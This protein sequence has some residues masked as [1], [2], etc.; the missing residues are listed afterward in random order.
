M[1][2]FAIL[3]KKKHKLIISRD[4]YGVKPFYYY[5]NK[6]KIIFSSEIKGI[7]VSNSKISFDENKIV[8]DEKYLE[9]KFTTLFK[10][11]EILPP[12]N[13]FEIDINPKQELYPDVE[14]DRSAP[15]GGPDLI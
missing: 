10:N 3:D 15:L 7:Y 6:N 8:Y 5:L 14:T 11:V 1:W 13:C 12:G 9:G 4:R 2:A